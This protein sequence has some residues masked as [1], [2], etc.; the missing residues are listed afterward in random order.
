MPGSG[1]PSVP[2]IF[3]SLPT[4]VWPP[5]LTS[6]LSCL[7]TASLNYLLKQTGKVAT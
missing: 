7:A 2:A 5:P 4:P 1:L 6:C 3:M